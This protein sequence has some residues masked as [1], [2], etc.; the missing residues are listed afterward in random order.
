MSFAGNGKQ[1]LEEGLAGI[2][3][4]QESYCV[5]NQIIAITGELKCTVDRTV[6][7]PGPV[8]W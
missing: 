6:K 1:I 5:K 8:V 7:G 2:D 4:I 3:F